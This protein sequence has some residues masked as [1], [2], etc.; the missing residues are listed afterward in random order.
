MGAIRDTLFGDGGKAAAKQQ[1]KQNAQEREFIMQQTQKAQDLLQSMYPTMQQN[2]MLG[3]QSALTTMRNAMPQAT[4]QRQQGTQNAIAALLGGQGAQIQSNQ[5]YIPQNLPNY[6][7]L[8]QQV[9]Q[10]TVNQ[11]AQTGANNAMM[12]QILARLR[13]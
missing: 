5:N 3:G 8:S 4:Y 12:Q 11:S 6:Q 9:P 10:Q 1:S 7:L 13:G 2:T